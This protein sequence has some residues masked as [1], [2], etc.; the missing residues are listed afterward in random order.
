MHHSVVP[1]K[2]FLLCFAAP[3]F[4]PWFSSC[5]EIFCH[6]VWRPSDVE[7]HLSAWELPEMRKFSEGPKRLMARFNSC[8]FHKER[9][10][11]EGHYKPQ[12]FCGT[13]LGFPTLS[14]ECNCGKATHEPIIGPD[15]SRASAE[16]PGEAAQKNAQYWPCLSCCSWARKNSSRQECLR[17]VRL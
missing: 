12:Q 16:Y 15:K 8:R 7:R 17:S 13:L 2:T 5:V 4:G 6:R 14:L 9:A 10:R 11:G 3:L 1:H